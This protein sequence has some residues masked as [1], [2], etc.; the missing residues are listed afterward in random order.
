MSQTQ[1]HHQAAGLGSKTK[2]MGALPATLIALGLVILALLG[3]FYLAGSAEQ[4][5][6][7]NVPEQEYPVKTI[8]AQPRDL[9]PGVI[10]FGS[11]EAPGEA[12]FSA[13]IAADVVEVRKLE[14]QSARADDL[15]IALDDSEAALAVTQAQA[16][17]QL[18]QTRHAGDKKVLAQEQAL[19]DLAV[20]EQQRVAKLV[21]ENLASESQ[22]DA[23]RQTLQRQELAVSQ[24]QLAVA[25]F[26]ARSAQLK[27]QLKRAELDLSRTKIRARYP[28][29]ITKVHVAAGDR[30][31][32]GMPLISLYDSSVIEVRALIPNRHLPAVQKALAGDDAA[33][34]AQVTIDGV[35][36]A[37]RLDRVAAASDA[38]RGGL[39]GFF[40]VSEDSPLLV[41]G[42]AVRVLLELPAVAKAQ[43]VPAGAVY[44]LNRIYR[45]KDDRLEGL[46]IERLG[47]YLAE[48][49][50][51][52]L[53]IRSGLLR[54][55]DQIVTT[56]LPN[57]TDGL[58]VRPKS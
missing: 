28:A 29:R 55:G 36:L 7:K 49:G 25:Q 9:R 1:S 21:Q 8:V 17:L 39:D 38:R 11:V 54:S 19:L 46:E 18:E 34:T 37:A 47:E 4:T 3:F 45:L 56:Q 58:K 40:R 32:P 42:R 13:A 50:S 57:A 31:S 35:R 16:N 33:I 2:K 43:P 53:L 5:E 27:A 22:R 26:S 41:R 51:P 14:G 15:L 20:R 44:G 52:Q 6:V 23:A 24:R 12:T 10:L 48:D 30:V